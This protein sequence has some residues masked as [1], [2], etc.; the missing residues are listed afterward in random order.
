[1]S[2]RARVK[3]SDVGMGGYDP[4]R[5]VTGLRRE[6][7][8]SLAAVS[9]DYYV[10]L[11]RGNLKG[12][13]EGILEAVGRALRL[14][15]DERRHLF[16]LARLANSPHNGHRTQHSQNVR[17]PV[18]MLLNSFAGPAWVRNDRMDLL[19][20]NQL[21]TALYAPIFEGAIAAPNKARFVFLDPTA[22][23][24]YPDWFEVAQSN[25]A[26]LRAA[27]GRN[28][29]D[30]QLSDL[31]GELS[32]RSD[33]FRSLWADH[34]VLTY[35]TGAAKISHP[36]VGDVDLFWEA[37]DLVADNG[38]TIIAYGAE[39]GSVS[40]ERLQLLAAWTA[41]QTPMTSTQIFE[42]RQHDAH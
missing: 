7:V 6:E 42:D 22:R 17:P 14:T 19:T 18:Q 29:Y 1:M 9:I 10:R 28:P 23:E 26:V 27:A 38:L 32:T 4:R 3:P 39:P 37:L 33:E 21:G 20:A 31:I 40:A 12:V 8:A 36:V 13:S 15:P 16:N 35:Q 30:K 25:V 34:D 41:P 2:R 5:R 24:F 11:E